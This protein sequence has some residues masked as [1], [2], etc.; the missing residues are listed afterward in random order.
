MLIEDG[1]YVSAHGGTFHSTEKTMETQPYKTFRGT[2]AHP[3]S[4]LSSFVEQTLNHAL[5]MARGRSCLQ[6]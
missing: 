5:L 4:D 6:T 2:L 3:N 1:R